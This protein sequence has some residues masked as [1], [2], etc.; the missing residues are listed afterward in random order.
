MNVI[1]IE[2][3]SKSDYD[4][5][6]SNNI[7]YEVKADGEINLTHRLFIEYAQQT[8]ANT[9]FQPSGISKSNA[10]Y[11]M[12]IYGEGFYK[13]K[14][15]IIRYLL[16]LNLHYHRRTYNTNRKEQT[17]GILLAESDLKPHAA[18]YKFADWV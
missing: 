14:T 11:Y 18:I 3:C 7:T 10:D 8:V 13:V 6:D 2:T 16:L 15:D 12:I 4:F 5:K 17:K 1:I 9:D